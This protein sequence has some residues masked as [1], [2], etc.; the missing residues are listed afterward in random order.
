MKKRICLILAPLLFIF[1][2]CTTRQFRVGGVQIRST[3]PSFV[4]YVDIA[5]GVWDFCARYY[6]AE[7]PDMAVE[8]VKHG[9]G[10]TL[11]DAIE[12]IENITGRDMLYMN[13]A[14]LILGPNMQD[15]R[16]IAQLEVLRRHKIYIF[17]AQENVLEVE[18]PFAGELFIGV[19]K[20]AKSRD[21]IDLVL[22][23]DFLDDSEL[24]VPRVALEQNAIVI[25]IDPAKEPSGSGHDI[26][27]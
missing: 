13:G 3:L 2:G 15:A 11:E 21:L 19:M 14:A 10:A 9:Y 17:R 22:I 1:C 23:G 8:S 16:Q 25:K 20:S 18:N 27:E 6:E 7:S 4:M 26:G 5:D 12:D 24:F